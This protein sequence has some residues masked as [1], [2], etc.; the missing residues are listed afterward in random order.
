MYFPVPPIR[1]KTNGFTLIEV[2]IAAILMAALMAGALMLAADQLRTSSAQASGSALATLN[3]A[4]GAYEAQF[5]INLANHTAIPVPGHAN[6]VN[7]YSPTTVE[8]FELGFLKTSVPT[9]V[10]GVAINPTVTNGTPSGLVWVTRPFT[11]NLGH[12]SQDLAGAAMISAGGDAAISTLLS[13]SIVVGVDGWNATNP[14]GNTAAILAMRNGAGSAAYVRLDGSTP[15]QG[16]LSFN[17]NNLSSVNTLGASTV[18][19]GTL[20]A[21]QA[22]VSNAGITNASVTN[23]SVTNL[24]TGNLTSQ[25]L[26]TTNLGDSVFFGTSSLYSD[27]WNTVIHNRS[28]ALYVQDANGNANPVVASQ[29]V[30]PGG[31]GVQIGNSFYYGDGTNSAIRQNGALFIQNQAGTGAASLDAGRV[32]AEEYLQVNGFANA[33]SGCA[34]N[35]LIGQNGAGSPLFC[36]NGVWV[37]G[38]SVTTIAVSS[39]NWQAAAQV[40]CPAGFNLTGGSCDM[41]RN[42]DGR[43]ISPRTCE[44]NGNGYFCNEGNGGSCIAHAVCAH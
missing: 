31:N 38:G 36:V 40:D 10:Y 16:S 37:A 7:P 5:S 43:E 18:S 23:A 26:T 35:G 25:S 42:G 27:G 17:G 8:L 2:G 3:T 9:G 41:F 32:T 30:T 13:P 28:G 21:S 44:P 11:D 4:V 39:G 19:T 15:M 33:G 6:V 34:P 14:V 20:N 29:L 12:P 1:K 22:N 24:S